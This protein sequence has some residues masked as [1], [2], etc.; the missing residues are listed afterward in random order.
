MAYGNKVRFRGFAAPEKRIPRR[1]TIRADVYFRL[2]S[3]GR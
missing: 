2:V 1:E 3:P